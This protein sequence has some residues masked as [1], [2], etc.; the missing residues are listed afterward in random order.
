M[1]TLGELFA[2]LLVGLVIAWLWR[3]HGIR[4]RA[5]SFVRQHCKNA[6]VQLLDGN[7]ALKG[8]RIMT[9]G[10]GQKRLAR[11]YGFEFTVTSQERLN[12]TVAMFGNHLGKIE[13]QAY[14]MPGSVSDSHDAIVVEPQAQQRSATSNNVVELS[15]WHKNQKKS[16]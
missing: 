4:E 13:M 15:D 1:I 5:L 3:G 16:D 7:V 2:W 12:G 8:W 14:L 6:G 10:Q 9:D 11:Q